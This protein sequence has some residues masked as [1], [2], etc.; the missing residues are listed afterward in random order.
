MYKCLGTIAGPIGVY[1]TG[2]TSNY[3]VSDEAVRTSDIVV[4]PKF[5]S[6]GHRPAAVAQTTLSYNKLDCST[7]IELNRTPVT[8]DDSLDNVHIMTQIEPRRIDNKTP[9]SRSH[10]THDPHPRM[11]IKLATV[12][13]W[14]VAI[15]KRPLCI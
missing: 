8:S 13:P 10:Y 14:Y 5:N 11:Y 1:N 4:K 15:D 6:I 9:L 7:I 2:T 3:L 12:T